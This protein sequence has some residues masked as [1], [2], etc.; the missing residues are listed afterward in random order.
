MEVLVG[1]EGGGKELNCL[2][3]LYLLVLG[4]QATLLITVGIVCSLHEIKAL[5]VL[6]LD[7]ELELELVEHA[8]DLGR[9]VRCICLDEVYRRDEKSEQKTGCL[10]TEVCVLLGSW[11][12]VVYGAGRVWVVGVERWGRQG[13]ILVITC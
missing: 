5:L 13:A 9:G 3:A 1:F 4:I 10:L 7:L 8:L 12:M 11:H 2:V 6:T